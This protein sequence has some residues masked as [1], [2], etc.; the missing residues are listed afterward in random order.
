MDTSKTKSSPRNRIAAIKHVLIAAQE[1]AERISK[2]SLHRMPEFFMAVRVADYFASQFRNFGYRLEP[3]V[4]RTFQRAD[5]R[6]SDLEQLLSDKEIRPNGRFDLVL[7]TGKKGRPAHIMEFKRGTKV[8]PLIKDAKRLAKV[9]THAGEERLKTN[10]LVFTRRF[11]SA[12]E[13]E[14][15][16][17]TAIKL[18]LDAFTDVRCRI[19]CTPPL[20][21][22]LD[23]DHQPKPGVK[24][25]AVIVE[26]SSVD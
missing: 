18:A 15:I 6:H 23:K 2:S 25:Q 14:E 11:S 26:I 12:G 22:F 21:S 10:Y 7:L 20:G 16:D 24:F 4:K 13:R 19:E 8:E 17:D 9:C 5:L 1:D 3:Q